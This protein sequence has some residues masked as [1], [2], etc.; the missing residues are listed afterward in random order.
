MNQKLQSF[1]KLINDNNETCVEYPP[2]L[3]HLC[4]FTDIINGLD[5]SSELM[6]YILRETDFVNFTLKTSNDVLK[7][8]CRLYVFTEILSKFECTDELT[9]S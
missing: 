7:V 3:V 4:I 8:I 2:L 1:S 9:M 6:A 5:I